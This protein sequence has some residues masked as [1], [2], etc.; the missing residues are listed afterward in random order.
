MNNIAAITKGP[1]GEMYE[2]AIDNLIYK[3]DPQLH[4]DAY[5]GIHIGG[6][7]ESEFAGKY[8][9]TCVRIACTDNNR[10]RAAKA[11]ENARVVIKSIVT[12]QRKD[13]YIGGL[14]EGCEKH[15][16]SVWNQ[17]FTMIGLCAFAESF[18]DDSL[19]PAA[20]ESARRIAQ[21]NAALFGSDRSILD[22]GNNGSQHLS[23]LLGLVR[24]ARLAPE[25]DIMRF[26]LHIVDCIKTSDNNFFKFNSILDLRSKKGIENFVIL[27]G[28]L[29]YGELFGDREALSACVKYWDELA[30]SQIRPN[31]NGTLHEVWTEGGNEPRFLGLGVNPDENCV[32][33]GWIELSL[34]LYYRLG[35]K[36]YID[37]V[38][39]SVFNHLLG[40][41]SNDGS[42]FAYYQPNFGH[43]ITKTDESM[44]KCCR[45]RG[46]SAVSMLPYMVFIRRSD[47]I[48]TLL[49]TNS[50]YE[51]DDIRL[52]MTS[53]Y[54]YT[55]SAAIDVINKT[56]KVRKI[57]IR[58]PDRI[59]LTVFHDGRSVGMNHNGFIDISLNELPCH[60]VLNLSFELKAKLIPV[61]I[62]GQKYFYGEYGN[63]LLAA[64]TDCPKPDIPSENTKSKE[65]KTAISDYYFD[66]LSS[67]S[68]N[69]NAV[70]TFSGCDDCH[71]SFM[72][73]E[74]EFKDFASAGRREG[75]AFT[76]YVRCQD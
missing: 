60:I 27:I 11:L 75:R 63:I 17:S 16:F 73:D 39:R 41:L 19:A 50:D 55:E 43:R 38:E 15:G 65:F 20:I 54:P 35:D 29:E 52:V 66:K 12:H 2:R 56:R 31:G 9:D 14:G 71:I 6:F 40:A 62:D 36:K 30:A 25:P 8:I 33:V 53:G 72:A 67:L 32:A 21:Y 10:A 51:D 44:Y 70:L 76:V 22:G 3:I 64:E 45:Y 24:L 7:A 34:A 37:A 42:D 48:E 26:I 1:L 23:L 68:I 13:G 47:T 57:R 18:P 74:L 28:I 59:G 46:Y 69:S 61:V 4:A 5:K 58:V 49:Y